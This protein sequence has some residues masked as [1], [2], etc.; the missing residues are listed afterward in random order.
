MSVSSIRSEQRKSLADG[1]CHKNDF[2][3]FPQTLFSSFNR[4]LQFFDT[5]IFIILRRL[6]FA[7]TLPS[8][9][10]NMIS[11]EWVIYLSSLSRLLKR[12]QEKSGDQ[13]DQ[14]VKLFFNIWPFA[15]IRNSP[16]MSQICQSR[17]RSLPIKK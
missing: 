7:W 5:F 8:T 1:F 15:T 17:L 13:Y 4:F 12:F 14:M 11:Y 3:F 9:R 6:F 2:S 16:I 10:K